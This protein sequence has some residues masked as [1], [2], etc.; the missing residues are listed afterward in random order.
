MRDSVVERKVLLLC[1]ELSRSLVFS[2]LIGQIPEQLSPRLTL[3]YQSMPGLTNLNLSDLEYDCILVAADY[4]DAD[5]DAFIRDFAERFPLLLVQQDSAR[6]IQYRR[7]QLGLQDSLNLPELT[8]TAVHH[9]ICAAIERSRAGARAVERAAFATLAGDV[10]SIFMSLVSHELRTPLNG[11]SLSAEILGTTNLDEEQKD[12]VGSIHSCTFQLTQLIGQILEFTMLERERLTRLDYEFC[13]SS[14][15]AGISD[16][17]RSLCESKAIDLRVVVDPAVPDMLIA[18]CHK[19]EQVLLNLLSNAVRF[20]DYG[21]EVGVEVALVE[22]KKDTLLLQISVT[23]TG[24]G[25][26]EEKQEIMFELFAK[27]YAVQSY[28]ASPGIGLGLPI[29]GKLVSILDGIIWVDSSPDEGSSFHF[30]VPVRRAG[31][32]YRS[33]SA[34]FRADGLLQQQELLN[35]RKVMVVD[36]SLVHQRIL[37]SLLRRWGCYVVSVRSAHDAEIAALDTSLDAVL[38]D[39][40][41]EN[42]SGLDLSRQLRSREGSTE[43]VPLVLIAITSTFNE[44][45]LLECD[46]AGFDGYIGRPYRSKELLQ[47]LSGC[48]ERGERR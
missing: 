17:I 36:D 9:A 15:L 37:G 45:N 5:I 12:L 23:D 32:A 20:T 10:K 30:T 44:M 46:Q 27:S 33:A 19:I 13:L 35:G 39:I 4:P 22:E 28:E 21:G 7:F 18:D 42:S 25:I 48:F 29:A 8:P 24:C 6:S 26:S 31:T 43:A 14:Y 34:A 40:S 16:R 2:D 47:V 3:D 41:T 1:R 38:V 11:I